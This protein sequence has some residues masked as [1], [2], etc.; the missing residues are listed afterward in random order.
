M[1]DRV[2]IDRRFRGPPESA[3]GGYA[4]GTVAQFIDPGDGAVA[5]TLRT[6][7][8]LDRELEVRFEGGSAV[9]RDGETLVAEG[10]AV[11]A[12]ERELPEPVAFEEAREAGGNCPWAGEHPYPTCFSCGP[13]RHP[14]D[15]LHLL[16]GPLPGR[17]V[18]AD[19]WAPDPAFADA[20]GVVDPKVV[21][22]ALDCPTGNGSFYFRPPA[23]P[24]LLGRLTAQLLA[25]VHAGERYVVMGW[26]RAHEGRKHWGGSTLFD[27]SGEPVAIAEG[28]W[29][30]LRPG[31]D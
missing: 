14:P 30:E 26:P 21:W 6:P 19:G 23:G 1:S 24:P 31:P 28:L 9:L 2:V 15:S 4:C 11:P 12:L 18:L 3:N 22:A 17:E 8:P 16:T 25:P 7:P 10:E 5:V 27:S 29:L 13:A 20:N